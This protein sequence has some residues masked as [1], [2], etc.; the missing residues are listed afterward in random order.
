MENVLYTAVVLG[1]LLENNASAPGV[2]ASAIKKLYEIDRQL[3]EMVAE[4]D[5]SGI[6]HTDASERLM[7]QAQA[8][9]G[10]LRLAN[11]A[12]LFFCDEQAPGQNGRLRL[13]IPGT[14]WDAD[15]PLYFF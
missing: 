7:V 6:D 8:L 1:N 13:E 10:Q 12:E 15:A 4:E 2:A 11:K 14:P 9:V 5:R 3:A